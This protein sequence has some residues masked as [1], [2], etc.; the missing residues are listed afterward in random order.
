[1][2]AGYAARRRSRDPVLPARVL[3]LALAVQI[4]PQKLPA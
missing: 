1:V 3:L 2:L 4:G